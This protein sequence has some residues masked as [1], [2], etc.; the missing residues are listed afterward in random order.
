[1]E[2]NMSF[3]RAMRD[4]FK[5]HLML[6]SFKVVFIFITLFF[7]IIPVG[8][9]FLFQPPIWIVSLVAVVSVFLASLFFYIVILQVNVYRERVLFYSGVI[10]CVPVPIKVIGRDQ[11]IAYINKFLCDNMKVK[12]TDMIGTDCT[13]YDKQSIKEFEAGKDTYKVKTT[14]F[15]LELGTKRLILAGVDNGYVQ[16]TRDVTVQERIIAYEKDVVTGITQNFIELA[17]GNLNTRVTIPDP[18]EHG[19]DIYELFVKMRDNFDYAVKS[20]KEII[21]HSMSSVDHILRQYGE[22]KDSMKVFL[23]R[24]RESFEKT[25]AA[26]ELSSKSKDNATIGSE[27]MK[28]LNT[29]MDDII[30]SSDDISKIIK[31][32]DE[33]A[34]QTNLLAL[35]AAVEAARAGK[36]GKGFAVVSEEVRNLAERSAKA[37]R[38]TTDLIEDSSKKVGAGNKLANKTNEAFKEIV[39]VI[40]RISTIITEIEATSRKE[41][42][43]VEDLEMIINNT[44]QIEQLKNKLSHFSL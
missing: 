14:N 36:H 33:I 30:R 41:A 6:L 44:S 20:I 40:N 7:I 9:S 42:K 28:S 24:T 1:M 22:I 21:S 26:L 31:V 25:T 12:M 29:S 15:Y 11:K 23:E 18:G 10:N 17:D 38:E 3:I 43:E 13:L 27:H 35:N 8:V 2:K 19:K 39:D 37:A 16:T 34:F 4:A 32:I 5:S